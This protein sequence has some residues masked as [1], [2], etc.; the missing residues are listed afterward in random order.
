VSNCRIFVISWRSIRSELLKTILLKRLHCSS[1]SN[2]L[3]YS[4][5][6]SWRTLAQTSNLLIDAF[7]HLVSRSMHR[8][9]HST[10]CSARSWWFHTS[11]TCK[12]ETSSLLP[13]TPARI[14]HTKS[15]IWFD[16]HSL[17]QISSSQLVATC[18]KTTDFLDSSSLRSPKIFLSSTKEWKINSTRIWC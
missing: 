2:G 14:R 5:I 11:S 12:K 16:Q 18:T 13:P 4:T 15:S 7:Q 17:S 10:S 1:R 6:S 9:A 3:F 8:Q